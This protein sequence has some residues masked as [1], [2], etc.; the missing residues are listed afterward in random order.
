[1]GYFAAYIVPEKG[2]EPEDGPDVASTTGWDAWAR[3]ALDHFQEFPAAAFLAYKGFVEG[4]RLDAL[5]HELERIVHAAGDPDLAGVTA[6]LLAA[7]RAM[8]AGATG[9]LV[10]DGEPGGDGA[11]DEGEE[12]QG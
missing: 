12:S 5:D 7:V 8:P 11:E 9:V 1:M 10:T 3:W 4:E 6:Q 2:G